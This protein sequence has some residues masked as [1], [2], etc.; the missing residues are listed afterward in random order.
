MEQ[1]EK[2]AENNNY[3]AI[4]IGCLNDLEKYSL[5]HPKTELS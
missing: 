4:N 2:I 1:I 5:T 3:T